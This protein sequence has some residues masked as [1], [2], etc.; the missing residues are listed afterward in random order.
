[1]NDYINECQTMYKE[2]FQKYFKSKEQSNI[3]LDRANDEIA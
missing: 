3:L 2:V 1:M